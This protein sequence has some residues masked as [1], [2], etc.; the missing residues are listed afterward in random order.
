[1]IKFSPKAKILLYILLI[2][3]VFASDSFKI[4][5]ILLALVFILSL[6]VPVSILKR[7]LLPIT[8]F[9]AFTFLSNIFFQTGKVVYEIFGINVTLEGLTKGAHL[10]LRLFILILGAKVLTAAAAAD[11][12]VKGMGGLLGPIGRLKSVKEFIYT[13]SLTLRFLPIIYNEA[14]TLYRETLKNSPEAAFTGK[15]KLSVSLLA[16]LFERSMKK[17]RELSVYDQ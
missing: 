10:S 6:N 2:I 14:Q 9:L 13:M 8:F 5:L 11:D 16:P 7:G 1:M 17:A 12:L 4:N 3:A 15:I